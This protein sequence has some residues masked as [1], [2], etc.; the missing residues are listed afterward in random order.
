MIERDKDEVVDRDETP[1]E[2]ADRNFNDILQEVRVTQ[3]GAA[4]LFSLLLTLPFTARFEDVTTF[5][6]RVYF[7]A[8]LLAAGTTIFLVAP[9][10]LHRV[11]FQTGEKTWVV[12]MSSAF[13]IIGTL[14]LCLTLTAVLLLV[15]DVLFATS[16][17]IAL[18]VVFAAVTLMLW[19]VPA[20]LRRP[21]NG[22]RHRE[23]R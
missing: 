19:F 9:V 22:R 10:S 8:L 3:T 15:T 7:V 13:A 1:A 6:E 12:R 20:L 5:Q 18:A 4:V 16:S 21:V 14:L 17:A 11:L 23:Q 2:R